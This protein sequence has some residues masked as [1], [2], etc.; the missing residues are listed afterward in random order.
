M[1]VLLVDFP[2]VKDFM[3][4]LLISHHQI[5]SL[6]CHQVLCFHKVLLVTT[7]ATLLLL[8]MQFMQGILFQILEMNVSGDVY[9]TPIKASSNPL[10]TGNVVADA[11]IFLSYSIHTRIEKLQIGNGLS[12]SM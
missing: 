8:L 10:V 3:A 4:M 9:P 5:L 1:E 7:I 12:V 11:G 2:E 6:Q